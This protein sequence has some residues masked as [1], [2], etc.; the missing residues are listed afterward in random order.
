[1]KRPLTIAVAAFCTTL[2]IA[3]C[4][5]AAEP[6]APEPLGP[7]RGFWTLSRDFV[8][9]LRFEGRD[10]LFHVHLPRVY[11]HRTRLPLLLVF[12]GSG[13]SFRTMREWTGFDSFAD[14]HDFV[15][16]YPGAVG[17]W[18]DGSEGSGGASD[19]D[20]TRALVDHLT[21]QWAVDPERLGLTGFSAGGFL[22]HRLACELGLPV[23]VNATVGATMRSATLDVCRV[24]GSARGV[25]A[26]LILGDE[27]ASVPLEG[28]EGTASL[29][30]SVNMW[31]SID[32]CFGDVDVVFWPD[33]GADPHVRTEVSAQC[34]GGTE[35]RSAVMAGLGHTWPRADTNPSSIDA[36]EI[37]TAFVTRQW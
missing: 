26:L 7:P 8:D 18:R 28:S 31:R 5:S 33:E 13:T 36:T 22:S 24:A 27:D 37:V 11:D 3:G 1:M 21:I 20:F 14:E 35:V 9:T 2:A 30:E 4:D 17:A 19:V 15:V 23:R 6:G 25:S 16:V 29:E 32:R 34:A 10:R 12:H